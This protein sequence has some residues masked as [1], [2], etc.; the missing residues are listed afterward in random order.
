MI[1]GY[2]E[3]VYV[4][5]TL[6]IQEQLVNIKHV[7]I[8]VLIMGDAIQKENVFVTKVLLG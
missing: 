4:F 7:Q 1:G 8:I 2:A 6:D 5:V 3:M